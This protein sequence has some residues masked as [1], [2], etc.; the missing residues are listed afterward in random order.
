MTLDPILGAGPIIALHSLA[1]LTAFAAGPVAILRH[2]RD[3]W[4]RIAGYVWAVAMLLTAVT[5][6]AIFE[7][8]LV[9]PFSPIHLLPLLVF[10]MVWRGIVAIRAGRIIEHG[11]IMVQLHLWSMGV[12]GLFT[13]L[14]GRRMNAVLFGGDSWTGFALAAVLFA[15][16]AR[17]LWAAQPKARSGA[18]AG[19]I[20]PSQRPG[21]S[22]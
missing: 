17:W 15:A 22:L 9:G 14:P 2:R 18:P 21:A 8:R 10:W 3:L 5:G 1:A 19:M 12:A 20:S 16:F 4:H 11:R 13:L 6:L 7:I